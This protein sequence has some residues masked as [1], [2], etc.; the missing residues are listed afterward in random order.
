MI[1]LIYIVKVTKILAGAEILKLT[2]TKTGT[3]V[4]IKISAETGTEP[5][6]GWSLGITIF[7]LKWYFFSR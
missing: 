1:I 2:E 4:Q 6:F 5:N 3:S 7:L